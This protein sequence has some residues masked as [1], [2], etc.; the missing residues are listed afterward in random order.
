MDCLSSKPQ[1]NDHMKLTDDIAN[2]NG[3]VAFWSSRC[4]QVEM[5]PQPPHI[6]AKFNNLSIAHRKERIT[7]EDICLAIS[8]KC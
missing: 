4:P 1:N 3:I 6:R 5:I 8:N 7:A 2:S